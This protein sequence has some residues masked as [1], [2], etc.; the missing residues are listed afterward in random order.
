M[1]L[2]AVETADAYRDMAAAAVLASAVRPAPGPRASHCIE[3]MARRG[4]GLAP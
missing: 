4:H 1:V 2:V 3:L